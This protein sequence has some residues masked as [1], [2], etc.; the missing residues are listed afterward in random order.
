MTALQALA[1]HGFGRPV[2]ALEHTGAD[3]TPLEDPLRVYMPHNGR[4]DLTLPLAP[5][6]HARNGAA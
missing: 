3:G 2:Q 1:E 4:D 6:P 5:D